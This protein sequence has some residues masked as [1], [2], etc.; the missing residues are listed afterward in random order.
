VRVVPVNLLTD[1][2]TQEVAEEDAEVMPG[3][4]VKGNYIRERKVDPKKFIQSSLRTIVV[5]KH[6]LIVGCEIP[7]VAGRCPVPTKVQS[8]L[9]PLSEKSKFARRL[10]K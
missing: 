5:G 10:A 3:I 8:I 1:E 9:H 6:R 2:Q 4:E 7:S